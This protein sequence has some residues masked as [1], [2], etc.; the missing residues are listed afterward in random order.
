MITQG[1]LPEEKRLFM[2]PDYGPVRR[3][4]YCWDDGIIVKCRHQWMLKK[5]LCYKGMKSLVPDVQEKVQ[6]CSIR[7]QEKGTKAE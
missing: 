7:K 4:C 2:Q 1:N 3:S 5:V 6:E